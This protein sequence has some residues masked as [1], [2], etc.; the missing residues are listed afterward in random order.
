MARAL[1]TTD[2]HK[3]TAKKNKKRRKVH[4]AHFAMFVIKMVNLQNAPLKTRS[5]ISA[6]YH[7]FSLPSNSVK[8]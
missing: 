1:L 6:N 4:I 7:L 5:H 8:L 2:H 3:D